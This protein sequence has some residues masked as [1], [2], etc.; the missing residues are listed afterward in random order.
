MTNWKKRSLMTNWKK[1]ISATLITEKGPVSQVHE[2]TEKINNP[3]EKWV[4]AI[5]R[6]LSIQSLVQKLN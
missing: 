1:K 4:G 3:I 2:E 6:H 5:K